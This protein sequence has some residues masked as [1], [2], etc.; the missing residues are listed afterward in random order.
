[1]VRATA[2]EFLHDGVKESNGRTGM[3]TR[4]CSGAGDEHPRV[5][6]LVRESAK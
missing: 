1:M 5:S 4:G 6:I 2:E 3:D